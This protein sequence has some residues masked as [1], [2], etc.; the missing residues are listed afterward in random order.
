MIKKDTFRESMDKIDKS[1]EKIN[2]LN[3]IIKRLE[4]LKSK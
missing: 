4:N 3:I 2:K 1:I